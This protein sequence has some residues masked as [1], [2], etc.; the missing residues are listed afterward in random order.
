MTWIK[1]SF[2]WML[3]RTAWAT[4]PSQEHVLAIRISRHGFEW[5]LAYSCLSSY[6]S[7][8]CASPAEWL[9]RKRTS[10]IRVQWDPERARD[11]TALPWRSIQIGLSGQAVHNYVNRWTVQIDDVTTLVKCARSSTAKIWRHELDTLLSCEKPYPL[12]E[13]LKTTIR[14]S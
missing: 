9:E 7:G 10:P 13:S 6:D 5:A 1:P 2:M 14:A 12:S 11:L 8:V 4:E 3:Y